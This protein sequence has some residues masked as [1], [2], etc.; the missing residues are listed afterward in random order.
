MNIASDPIETIP[1]P[2]VLRHLLADTIRRRDLLRALLRVSVRKSNWQP[3]P[4]N[5]SPAEDAT[6]MSE[7]AS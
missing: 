1:T 4:A 6:A 3:W 7:A 5:H 2:D